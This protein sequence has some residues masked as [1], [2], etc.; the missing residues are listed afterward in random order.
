MTRPIELYQGE[1]KTII[2]EMNDYIS[3]ATEIEFYIDTDTQIKKTLTG[4]KVSSVTSTQFQVQIDAADTE[5]KDAGAYKFQARATIATK[6]YNIKFTPN[7]VMILNSI[8]VTEGSGN[9]YGG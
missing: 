1:D 3:A 2:V 4:G 6:K 5:T 8:F 9:D 7:K